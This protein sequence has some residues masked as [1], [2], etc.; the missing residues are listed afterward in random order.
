MTEISREK[1]RELME[2]FSSVAQ[3]KRPDGTIIYACDVA[4]KVRMQSRAYYNAHRNKTENFT[5]RY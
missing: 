3:G 1:Q 4:E 5:H 2:S